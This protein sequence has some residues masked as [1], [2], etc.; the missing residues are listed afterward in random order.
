MVRALLFDG[1]LTQRARVFVAAAGVLLVVAIFVPLWQMTMV[2]NQYPEGLRL[3][4]YSYKLEGDLQ[5]INILNH[6][7]GMHPLEAAYFT[8]LQ[9]LPLSFVVGGVLCFVAALLRRR[10]I[11]SVVLVGG[12]VSGLGTMMVLLYRL[13]S[14]GSNL[15]PRAAIRIQPF[16]P[17]PIGINQLANFRVTTFFHL[18]SVFFIVALLGLAFA[19]WSSR[20]LVPSESGSSAAVAGR[21]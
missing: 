19:L 18:G 14:Y 4:I 11:T 12:L 16:M 9:V 1:Q 10:V 15:D 3:M 20:P 21:A 17:A 13:Y 8:E 6:Y 5:E 2:S 7:I